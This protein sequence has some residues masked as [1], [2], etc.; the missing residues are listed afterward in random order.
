[1]LFLVVDLIEL[2]LLKSFVS[3]AMGTIYFFISLHAGLCIMFVYDFVAL[4]AV[5]PGQ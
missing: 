1:M 3:M 4:L 2:V 5:G